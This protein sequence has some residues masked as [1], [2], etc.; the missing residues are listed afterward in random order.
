MKIN[1]SVNK[2]VDSGAGGRLTFESCTWFFLFLRFFPLFSGLFWI[3][4]S[5]V[6]NQLAPSA[7]PTKSKRQICV[8]AAFHVKRDLL[9]SHRHIPKRE[10]PMRRGQREKNEHEIRSR[11]RTTMSVSAEKGEE[12]GRYAR[13]KIKILRNKFSNLAAYEKID[14]HLAKW[15][16]FWIPLDF[17]N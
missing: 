2:Q 9:R 10:I 1:H 12:S 16:A 3:T 4:K 8:D 13:R 14:L 17:N 6:I 5:D 11:T 7:S 15:A